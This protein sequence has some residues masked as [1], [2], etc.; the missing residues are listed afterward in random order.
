MSTYYEAGR[1][2]QNTNTFY[3]NKVVAG[4]RTQL[5]TTAFTYVLGTI[6]TFRVNASG[7]TIWATRSGGSE[8]SVTDSSITSGKRGGF[9]L[10]ANVGTAR[11][12]GDN[13]EAGD[14]GFFGYPKIIYYMNSS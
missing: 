10:N 8:L 12:R 7:S 1:T 3:L 9:M 11:A 5:A 2:L 4:T 13:F 6:Y 14:L